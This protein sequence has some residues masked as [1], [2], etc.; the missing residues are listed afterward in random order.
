MNKE[1]LEKTMRQLAE[2]NGVGLTK[3]FDK[4][5]NAKDRFG[6]GLSCPCDKDNE[7]RFCISKQCLQDI[8][9][10]GRCH[11]NCFCEVK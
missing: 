2:A 5:V 3:N 6:I 10:T 11:C 4:I 9:E 1:Q 7:A 8:K